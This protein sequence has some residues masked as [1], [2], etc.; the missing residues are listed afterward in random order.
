MRS[1]DDVVWRIPHRD[2]AEACR[3]IEAGSHSSV[4]FSIMLAVLTLV[5]VFEEIEN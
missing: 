3:E 4:S 1:S 2:H 5:T